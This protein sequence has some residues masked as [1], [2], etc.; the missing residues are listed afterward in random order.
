MTYRLQD[1]LPI[2]VLRQL[3]HERQAM[4]RQ[5]TDGVREPTVI[6]RCKI[7]EV[8]A[9]R[10]DD[11]LHFERGACHLR[12]PRLADT[13]ADNLQ[14]FN[15]RR[16]RLCA[17]CVMPN[18]VHVVFRPFEGERLAAILHSWKSYTS[19]VASSIVGTTTLWA[20]EYF[21]RVIRDERHLADAIG[22]VRNNPAK[23]ALT[24]WKWVG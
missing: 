5:L 24:G 16:Y 21:D 6:E 14:H 2:D 18:H 12:N 9:V 15:E 11:E 3:W 1:S 20:R 10:L 23:A 17:W 19:H 7:E 4:E 8:F 22:Y 13:V